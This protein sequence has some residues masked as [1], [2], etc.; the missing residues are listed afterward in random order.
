MIQFSII[1]STLQ[2]LITDNSFASA[3]PAIGNFT[4]DILIAA[5]FEKLIA[6]KCVAHLLC[7]KVIIKWLVQFGHVSHD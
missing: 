2:T 6:G 1:W 5:P 7:L 4:S 3:N